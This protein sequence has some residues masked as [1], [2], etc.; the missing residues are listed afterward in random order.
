VVHPF[1]AAGEWD[2]LPDLGPVPDGRDLLRSFRF[3]FCA[4]SRFLFFFTEGF[5]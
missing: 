3:R 5:S 1:S 4:S 2:G